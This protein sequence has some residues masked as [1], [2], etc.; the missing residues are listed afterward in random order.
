LVEFRFDRPDVL[1]RASVAHPTLPTPRF[2]LQHPADGR[3]G[4]RRP[5][6]RATHAAGGRIHAR[7]GRTSTGTS[8]PRWAA[9]G[10]AQQSPPSAICCADGGP[11]TDTAV[12]QIAVTQNPCDSERVRRRGRC[13]RA[14]SEV[15]GGPGFRRTTRVTRPSSLPL[16]FHVAIDLA[17]PVASEIFDQHTHFMPPRIVHTGCTGRKKVDVLVMSP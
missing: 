10:W 4:H 6:E 1:P 7:N 5:A 2:G 8:R 12:T 13:R 16:L 3:L 14:R 11:C 17:Y 15:S 9:A